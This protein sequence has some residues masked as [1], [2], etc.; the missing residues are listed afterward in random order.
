MACKHGFHSLFA[1]R[2]RKRWFLLAW[3]RFGGIMSHEFMTYARCFIASFAPLS[4]NRFCTL[5]KG[6]CGAGGRGG[7]KMEQVRLPWADRIF[8][9]HIGRFCPF[10]AG[11]FNDDNAFMASSVR[12][13]AQLKCRMRLATSV[14]KAFRL[15]WHCGINGG[16][17]SKARRGHQWWKIEERRL[18]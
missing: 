1:S 10:V 7:R 2:A 16:T 4:V 17:M 5:A 9:R 12:R 14:I 13:R 15:Q 11:N 8:S 3:I 6:V 18:S